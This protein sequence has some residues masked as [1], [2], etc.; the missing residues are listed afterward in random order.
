M[1]RLAVI[2]K[3]TATPTQSELKADY[4]RLL[5]D[6]LSVAELF[7]I[8]DRAMVASRARLAG[9]RGIEREEYA[10]ELVRSEAQIKYL[11][12]KWRRDA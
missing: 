1:R 8:H 11:R 9:M 7:E 10:E 5:H 2:S 3:A 6:D 4:A 12:T